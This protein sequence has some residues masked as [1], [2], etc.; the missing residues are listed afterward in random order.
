MCLFSFVVQHCRHFFFRGTG[1][2][3]DTGTGQLFRLLALGLYCNQWPNLAT[4][5]NTLDI[6]YIYIFDV[7]SLFFLFNGYVKRFSLTVSLGDR[8]V[9][10]FNHLMHPP[11]KPRAKSNYHLR[12]R[13][14]HNIYIYINVYTFKDLI[15][16]WNRW[17]IGSNHQP[18]GITRNDTAKNFSNIMYQW[19]SHIMCDDSEL[20]S[21]NCRMWTPGS[22]SP[23]W[24][25][26]GVPSPRVMSFGIK[27]CTSWLIP[28]TK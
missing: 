8:N 28:L 11:S 24:L 4:H 20:S 14:I 27:N 19:D 26:T 22:N 12:I 1:L 25:I 15:S 5:W 2:Y 3:Q 17:N 23:G 13:F 10:H 9:S 7:L 6:L 16:T 21:I 18:M